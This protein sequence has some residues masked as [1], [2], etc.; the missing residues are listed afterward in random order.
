MRESKNLVPGGVGREGQEFQKYLG[1]ELA[2]FLRRIHEGE[3]TPDF[4]VDS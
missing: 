3:V 1:E 4:C 2:A